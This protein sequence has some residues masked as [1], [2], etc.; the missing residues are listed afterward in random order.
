MSGY[1]GPAALRMNGRGVEFR[2]LGS[3]EVDDGGLPVDLGG[4][5]ERT[6]L[7]RLLLA[8]GQVVSAERLAD[9]LWAGEPPPHS[10]A[11]LRVYVSRLRRALGPAAAALVTQPPGYRLQVGPGQLDASRFESLVSVARRDL[12]EGKPEAA[13]AGL[14]TALALWRGTPLSDVADFAFAQADVARLEEARLGALEDRVEA[15]LA[16]G[17]HA[18]LVSELDGLVAAHPLRE[19]LCGQQMLALYRCGRQADAL[20]VYRDLR[21]RLAD[22]LGIDPNPRLH[23]LHEAIL[24]Q[25]PELDWDP[26]AGDPGHPPREAAREGGRP[27]AGHSPPGHSPA[28]HSPAGEPPTGQSPA[29]QPPVEP[30]AEPRLAAA[31]VPGFPVAPA[32]GLPAETTSFVGREAELATIKD[33]LGLS[34]LLTLTGP[35]GS[36]KTRLALR[37]G[38]QASSRHPGGVWLVELAQISRPELVVPAT[39]TAL[40]IREEPGR[41]LLDSIIAGLAGRDL[42]L[43]IDNCEH[44]VDAVAELAAALLRGCPEL[45]ILATSQ[46]RLGLAGEA[47]WPVPPLVLPLPDERDPRVVAEAESVRL[48]CD[49]AALAR[50]GF[51]LTAGNVGPVSEICRRLDGIPLALELA[52]A[53]VNALSAGQLAAR[54]DDRFRLLAGSGRRG[55]PRH[56][57]LQA[58]IEWSHD[59]LSET[60]QVCL[61]RLAIFAGGCT[62]EAAEAVCPGSPLAPELVFQTV[63]SLVDRSLLTAEER[64]GSMRYGMLESIH[65]FAR[66]KL[67]EAGEGAELSG[68]LLGWLLDF[69]AQADLD[70]PDQGAWL[71]LLESELD[72]FRAGL[73][74]SLTGSGPAPGVAGPGLAG[75]PAGSAPEAAPGLTGSARVPGVA[76]PRPVPDPAGP[77]AAL[78]LAGALAPFWMVRGHIGLG[79]RWLDAAL[80]AAGPGAD[81]RLRA[82]ALDGAGQLAAVHADFAAQEVYQQESLAIWRGFGEAAKVTSCL[83]DLGAAAHIRGDYAAARALYT[84]ALALASEAGLEQQMARSLSGL[85]RLALH[86]GDL[87]QA[88]EYYTESM[89]LFN[90]V[91]DLRRATLILGNLGVTALD[92]GDP[93]LAA[94]RLEEHLANARKLGDRKLI[95]GA[96]TNLGMIAHY[97]GD[98]ER[99]AGQHAEALDLAEQVG[100]RRLA[101]VALTNLGLTALARKDFDAARAFHW[102]SL[103]LAEAVGERRCVVE[104][105]E[106]IAE[107]DTA[108]GNAE[109]AAVLFGASRALRAMIGSPVPGQDLARL[110]E[111]VAATE[112]ALGQERFRA[113]LAA[114]EAMSLE[115]AVDLARETAET[116]T[117][118]AAGQT[119]TARAAGQTSTAR[120]AGQQSGAGHRAGAGEEG[121]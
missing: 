80:A 15:D 33:L 19:R 37:A 59:L 98:L 103:E 100:D 93:S 76:G 75:G 6:L 77:E 88:T 44:V 62:L 71:D 107:A 1:D 83:G 13:A 73:E 22:E 32:P 69:A 82:I 3:V 110:T 81:P 70:G 53:R 102:R 115:Q 12:D 35:G 66:Q 85:G 34:R 47:S 51:G 4:L 96:L 25:L 48:F 86:A 40:S 108:E 7:A 61:R 36:G 67:A 92:Q 38:A 104:S 5:R 90:A 49:R 29:G 105:L 20:R 18:A 45:R 64:L 28:G 109:R 112:S 120:A 57:T 52:A 23:R 84:E 119:S 79:R 41:P 14:R 63:T 94:A 58:A 91:G 114:G 30:A 55:L 97:A 60:E 101:A 72:N 56:R 121:R 54:L 65:Q 21:T 27:S 46:S 87:A 9:D 118:R 2:I 68:R 31:P 42:L 99:A 39:A 10:M 8:A 78:A 117:A 111:S 106:A 50:P 17:R 11:T 43:I 116:S 16:C 113:A 24:R 74:W 89:S 95:G 26:A